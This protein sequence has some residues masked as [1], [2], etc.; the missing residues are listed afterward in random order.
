MVNN[1]NT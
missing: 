1:R